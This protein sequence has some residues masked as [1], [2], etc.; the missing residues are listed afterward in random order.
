MKIRS[1][2]FIASLLFLVMPFSVHAQA[3]TGDDSGT[4][5]CSTP[6]EK[7]ACQA[8]LAQ[9]LAEEAQAQQQL[10]QAQGQSASLQQAINVLNAKIKK[11]QLAIKAENLVIQTL[12]N[13][14]QDKTNHISDLENQISQ[15]KQTLA[16]LL[17]KTR[18]IDDY[19]LPEILLS[20]STV[21]GFFDDVDT[22]GSLQQSLLNTFNQLQSDEASTSAEKDAL[23]T[24]Q[25][26]EMDAKYTIQQQASAVQ[27]DEAQQKQLL[28]ISKGNEKAYNAVVA[29]KAAAAGKIRAALFNLAGGSNPI[30]FGTA[31]QYADTASTKTGVPPAFLLAILKQESNL[32]G[33]VG[34]CYLTDENTGA[35]V[36][37]TTG[38]AVSNVMKPTRDVPIFMD[39]TKA[40]GLD[41]Y[42]TIV[43]CQ[44][45][46][47]GWGGAMGPA[48][49]IPSTWTLLADRV[50]SALGIS[51]TPNPWNPEHAIM[52]E[53]LYM[54][55]LGADSTS[56]SAQKNA[57]CK[58]YSGQP[59]GYV[60]GATSYGNSV[61]NLAYFNDNSIQSQI[62]ALQ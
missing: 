25:N 6:A 31:L 12:G 7:T 4:P 18:E 33:N 53:A 10:T 24:K 26:A 52:A 34:K 57:A 8:E 14:I 37:V 1:Y 42:Q 5:Q 23:T 32:G 59:C 15:G 21:A 36:Y 60:T 20:Q 58:Y 40:L 61:L 11:A 62:D 2:F 30:P 46:G 28:S 54:S 19:S 56:Y 49:F 44:L 38:E 39:I 17:R 22:F 35:G 47:L 50:A 13:D 3:S 27:A 41:P 55:D 16:D 9:V 45:G 51:D 48:Q 43:S 29:A